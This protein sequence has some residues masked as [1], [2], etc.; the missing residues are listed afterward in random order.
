[1]CY[2]RKIST[3]P[4]G[5]LTTL[6]VLRRPI[7]ENVLYRY[8][9]G[10]STFFTTRPHGVRRT[11]QTV[12]FH[13]PSTLFPGSPGGT[14]SSSLVESDSTKR[15]SHN[16]DCRTIRRSSSSIHVHPEYRSVEI[17]RPSLKRWVLRPEKSLTLHFVPGCPDYGQGKQKEKLKCQ[18]R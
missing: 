16:H 4:A 8:R 18:G 15:S 9:N 13:S 3:T 6:E 14:G 11:T 7:Q 2:E 5:D 1:M 17:R 12:E 10:S